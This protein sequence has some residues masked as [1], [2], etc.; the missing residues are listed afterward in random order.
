VRCV[1]DAGG[2]ARQDAVYEERGDRVAETEVNDAERELDELRRAVLEDWL[3]LTDETAGELTRMRATLSWRI[4]A[5]LRSA[6][7]FRNGVARHGLA[8]AT[9]LSAVEI[10][11]RLNRG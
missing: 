6:A 8:Q 3:A 1:A 11:R 10:A 9:R 2:C 7:R 4:T 5:P